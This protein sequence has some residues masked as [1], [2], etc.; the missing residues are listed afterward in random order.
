MGKSYLSL[1]HEE[2][3]KVCLA[4]AKDILRDEKKKQGSTSPRDFD[5][6]F[7]ALVTDLGQS[8]VMGRS[9]PDRTGSNKNPYASAIDSGLAFLQSQEGKDTFPEVISVLKKCST[10]CLDPTQ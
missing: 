6:A 5:T 8:G 10:G 7:E 4:F 3:E 9:R 2:L 1:C